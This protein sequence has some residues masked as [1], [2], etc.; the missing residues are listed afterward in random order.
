MPYSREHKERT[1]ERIVESAR[2]LFNRHGFEQ[3]SIDQ[4][5][6]TAGL[7]RGGFYYHFGSKDALYAEA[8][9]S[10]VETN[11]FRRALQ[12]EPGLAPRQAAQM[13]LDLYLG[14][15]VFSDIDKHCPL[16]ALP[17]DVAR[18]GQAPQRAYTDLARR[19]M[20]LFENAMQGEPD[21]ERRAQ[22]MVALCVG[23][24]VLARTTDDAQLRGAL[25]ASAHA[26]ALALLGGP[27]QDPRTGLSTAA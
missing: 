9:T 8:V 2:R 22:A 17:G 15:K 5:M 10:F 13:L 12:D 6:A 7:T 27:A 20:C 3:V 23:A 19:M 11:P 21:A 24:M 1:R 16:Y 26:Q 25:R 18:A 14:D 4:I